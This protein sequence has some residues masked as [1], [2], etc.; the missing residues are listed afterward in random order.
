[1]I[2]P[3]NILPASL[4]FIQAAADNDDF[5]VDTRNDGRRSTH[6]T[7]MILLQHQA[8]FGEIPNYSTVSRTRR[9]SLNPEDYRL[10]IGRKEIIQPKKVE[11]GTLRETRALRTLDRDF[12]SI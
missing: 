12:L 4:G 9:T 2:I 6:G 8:A 10:L 3:E 7:T 11:P 5:Q 1:M